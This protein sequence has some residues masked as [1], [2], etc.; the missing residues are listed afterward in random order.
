MKKLFFF[1]F[2]TAAFA[3]N[4]QNVRFEGYLADLGGVT[5]KAWYALR[6]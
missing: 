5:V 1:L 4:A 2:L 3:S 6:F